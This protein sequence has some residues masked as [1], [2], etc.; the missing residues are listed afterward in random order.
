MKNLLFPLL[1][2]TTCLHPVARGEENAVKIETE[3]WGK[4]SEGNPVKRFVLTNSDGH[5]IALTDWGATLLE[6]Y[7]PNREG[8]LQNVNLCMDSLEGYQ[9]RHPHFGG[10]IGRYA[11]RI[12]KGR[13][14]IDGK[15]YQL[16]TNNGPNHL[17]GGTPSYDHR[18]W[19]SETYEAR[20][21]AGVRFTLIDP[22]GFNGY[23][24]TVTVTT[25]YEWNEANELKISF[26]ATSDAKTHINLTNHSYWNLGGAG[27]GS[28][29]DHICII[30]GDHVLDVDETLIPTGKFVDVVGTPFDFKMPHPF[31]ERL[32]Q[33]SATG[34]YDH[35]YV[36]RGK[37]GKLRA[38]ARV[39]D[40]KTG[41]VLEIETTQPG[42][43]LYTANHLP[44]NE[45]SNGY[46]G[47]QAFCLET[48]HY[49]DS[50]NQPDFPS[51]LLVPGKRLTEVTIHRFSVAP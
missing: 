27:S 35:C 47:H 13:F 26:T 36:V 16:E 45:N 46:G 51:T 15:D 11:N 49:P 20:D 31:A 50:P 28:A 1:L 43:Q 21:A 19:K 40:P 9:Q 12:A 29:M 38:A 7:V 34:G 44:G 37:P 18:M 4:T 23:P 3:S 22:D 33:L 30:E 17:H 5:S 32:D 14:S 39:T 8:K 25:E 10:T 48:Q 41:R 42:M 24:G 2:I 6:V